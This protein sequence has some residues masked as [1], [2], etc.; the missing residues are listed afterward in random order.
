MIL[1]PRN[2]TRNRRCVLDGICQPVCLLAITWTLAGCAFSYVDS[3]NV[4][5]VIGFVDVALP[6]APAE[7][8]GPTPSVVSVT[9]VGM[10]VY[11][12]TSNG[13]GVVLGYGKE[14]VV[15]MPNN[16][17]IDLSGPGLCAAAAVASPQTADGK[18]VP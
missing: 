6:A 18:A 11:S 14:T 1:E 15:V 10:H 16:A 17:C 2:K 9:S 3:S 13:S 12:G 5:H 7:V 4:R 8:V